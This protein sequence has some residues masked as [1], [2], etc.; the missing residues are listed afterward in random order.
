MGD[1]ISRPRQIVL[2]TRGDLEGWPSY[3][4]SHRARFVRTSSGQ[5]LTDRVG[6]LIGGLYHA[7]IA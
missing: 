3:D 2:T 5:L 1:C 7:M 4:R 6:P